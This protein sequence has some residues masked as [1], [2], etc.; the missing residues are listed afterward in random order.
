MSVGGNREKREGEGGR[1]ARPF[2]P[3]CFLLIH[4]ATMTEA[5]GA[6]KEGEP[7]ASTSSLRDLARSSPSDGKDERGDSAKRPRKADVDMAARGRRMFGL[8]NSTLSKAKEDN[9]RRSSGEAVS[10]RLP[11]RKG[12]CQL[13]IASAALDRRGSVPK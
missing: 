5:D 8:L 13:M 3:V 1:D 10:V 6:Q 11:Y 4:S 7:T 9:A 12:Y 2:P